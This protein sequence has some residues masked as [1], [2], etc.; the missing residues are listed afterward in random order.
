M[1]DIAVLNA[2]DYAQLTYFLDG[3][4]LADQKLKKFITIEVCTSVFRDGWDVIDG[5]LTSLVPL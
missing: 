1:V 3:I 4:T 5:R 2:I